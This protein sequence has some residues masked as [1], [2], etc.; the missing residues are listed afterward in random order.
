[1]TLRDARTIVSFW[2][3]CPPEG[4]MLAMLARVYTTWRPPMTE[5]EM[6]VEH[7]RSLQRRWSAG[8]LSAKD[9]VGMGGVIR[10]N[11]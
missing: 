4:E 1:M 8:A 11:E 10:S 9:I 7:R 6:L 3:E 5:E 2:R